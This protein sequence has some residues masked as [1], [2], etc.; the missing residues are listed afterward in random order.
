MVA[1]VRGSGGGRD[2]DVGKLWECGAA[3][4]VVPPTQSGERG[5]RAAAGEPLYGPGTPHCLSVC[6]IACTFRF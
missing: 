1:G 5:P 2:G 4:A 6:V 3:G